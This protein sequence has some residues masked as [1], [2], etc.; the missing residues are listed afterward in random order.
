[1]A[2][3][4]FSRTLKGVEG[5]VIRQRTVD[6]YINATQLC[7]AHTQ[8]TNER[9]DASEWFETEMAKSALATLS[10]KLNVPIES[11]SERKAGRSGGTWIHPRLA[12]RFSMWLDDDFSL[13]VE[14]W[15]HE[16]VTT[17]QN[18]I[19]M[20]FNELNHLEAMIDSVL[21]ALKLIHTAVHN[22]HYLLSTASHQLKEIRSSQTV[23]MLDAKSYREYASR[24]D[25]VDS[26]IEELSSQLEKLELPEIN[27]D[28][29]DELE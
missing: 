4:N 6:G 25:R 8:K 5:V 14:D 23:R 17:A 15:V 22:A 28:D 24:V 18:P 29:L 2:L 12:V 21:Q 11:L 9:K 1:M 26:K 10:K 19:Q 20:T 27:S 13:Q 16:W 7:K 3:A